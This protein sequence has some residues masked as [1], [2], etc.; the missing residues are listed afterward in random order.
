M[1]SPELFN[2]LNGLF[3]SSLG[4]VLLVCL[5]EWTMLRYNGYPISRY[6]WLW[7]MFR[8]AGQVLRDVLK[9]TTLGRS[10]WKF[11]W[12][13]S[14]SAVKMGTAFVA[15]KGYVFPMKIGDTQFSKALKVGVESRIRIFGE[16]KSITDMKRS[17]Y[18]SLIFMSKEEGERE[19]NTC[20]NINFSCA[21]HYRTWNT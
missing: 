5:N 6:F 13:W 12:T 11:P 2:G 16:W 9:Q 3:W 17:D 20:R 14:V 15:L 18:A 7:S 4:R 19:M 10:I 1:D 8:I 21:R